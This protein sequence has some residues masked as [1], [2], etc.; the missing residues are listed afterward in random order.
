MFSSERLTSALLD[1][2][3]HHV[4]ILDMS[5]GS[6]RLKPIENLEIAHEEYAVSFKLEF[7]SPRHAELTAWSVVGRKR[8]RLDVEI[9]PKSAS[10]SGGII[11]K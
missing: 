4:H 7:I 8:L 11:I 10:I 6:Y 2:L 3:T 9:C 5:G 1:Q